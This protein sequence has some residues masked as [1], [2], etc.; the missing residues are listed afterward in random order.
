MTLVGGDAARGRQIFFE[1]VDAS[2]LRCHKIVWEGGDVGPNLTGIGK[3]QSREY[4]LQSIIAPKAHIAEGFE[5]VTLTMKDG[6][7]LDG[8]VKQ[9]TVDW[10]ELNSPEDGFVQ[11][12]KS[13][14]VSR[15]SG[16]SG[17]LEGFGLILSKRDLRDLVEFLANLK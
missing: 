11:L 16:T 10:R 7:V 5:T 14:I 15:F 9:E 4:L 8:A 17:I 13:D 12:S 1:R 3:K 2:C 6:S